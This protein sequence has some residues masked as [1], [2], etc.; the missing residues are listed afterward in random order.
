MP[1]SRRVNFMSDKHGCAHGLHC[2]TLLNITL[3]YTS[4]PRLKQLQFHLEHGHV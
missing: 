3:R 1:F 2:S 4:L